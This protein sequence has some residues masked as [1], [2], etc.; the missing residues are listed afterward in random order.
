MKPPIK[1]DNN[2]TAG[3]QP[4]EDDLAALAGQGVT[5]IINLR[6]PAS[7]I[8]QSHRKPKVKKP[9]RSVCAMCTCP[10]R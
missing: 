1:I 10:S 6:R 7:P 9:G 8:N 4:D 5:T 2:V 3:A